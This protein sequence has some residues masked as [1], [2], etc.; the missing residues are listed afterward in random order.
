MGAQ[1]GLEGDVARLLELADELAQRLHRER[2]L[3]GVAPRR[4]VAVGQ[5]DAAQQRLDREV[6]HEIEALAAR[7]VGAREV[8]RADL[9]TGGDAGAVAATGVD[10][11]LQVPADRALGTGLHTGVAAHAQLEVDRVVLRPFELEGAEVAAE[12]YRLARPHRIGVDRGQLRVLR[13]RGD[14]HRRLE[15]AGQALG[16]TQRRARL[17]D[18]QEAASGGHLHRRHR[19]GIGQR[20]RGGDQRGE[21]GACGGGLRRPAGVLAQVEEMD[22]LARALRLGEL[23]EERGLLRAGDMHRVAARERG[24]ERRQLGAAQRVVAMQ[25]GAGA[26]GEARSVERETAVAVA[27]MNARGICVEGRLVAVGH[28]SFHQS[29]KQSSS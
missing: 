29:L 1:A 18:D 7:G 10:I 3:E 22:A 5:L 16:P 4:G 17:A 23:A 19:L 12:P 28:V 8:D 15:A 14:Q 21:L 11:D 9:A 2:L 27:K 13:A 25:R 24:L 26:T 20:G 6:E